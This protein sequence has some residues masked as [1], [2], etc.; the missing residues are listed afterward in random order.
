MITTS[1]I[2]TIVNT[3]SEFVGKVGIV[4]GFTDVLVKVK[5]TDGT[6]HYFFINELV[7]EKDVGEID[8][9]EMQ[10]KMFD[11]L[12]EPV[13]K[14]FVESTMEG[15]LANAAAANDFN[16]RMYE[17]GMMMPIGRE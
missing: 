5:I 8:I 1:T 15:D 16:E 6:V 17:K 9:T 4:V 11:E 14:S 7:V 3:D 2:V 10:F 12:I 13:V